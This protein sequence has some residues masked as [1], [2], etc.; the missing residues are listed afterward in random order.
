[1]G[2]SRIKLLG[3]TD[4]R[5]I[6]VAAT[7]SPGTAIHT[8][9][10]GTGADNFDELYLEAYNS[11][12]T[13]RTLTIE[14]GGTTAPDDNIVLNIPSKVGLVPVVMGRVLQNGGAV[15]AFCDVANKVVLFGDAIRIT[16]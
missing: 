15:K 12:T 11:D 6:K 16:P 8:A 5:G 10:S 4:G 1:M 14:F 3:S 2:A 13:A 9:I 7:A